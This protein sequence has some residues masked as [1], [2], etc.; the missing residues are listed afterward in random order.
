MNNRT[1]QIMK[2]IKMS[3]SLWVSGAVRLNETDQFLTY[4]YIPKS[5]LREYQERYG[6]E[7]KIL[8]PGYS[9]SEV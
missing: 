7:L 6:D 4:I 2:A 9:N 5:K 3:S 1:W 8:D